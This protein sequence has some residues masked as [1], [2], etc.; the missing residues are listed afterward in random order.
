MEG[1]TIGETKWKNGVEVENGK[2]VE[3]W[4][5]QTKDSNTPRQKKKN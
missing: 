5:A 2:S 4:G 1:E 3:K